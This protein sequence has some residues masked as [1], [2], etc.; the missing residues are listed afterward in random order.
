MQ[1]LLA[2]PAFVLLTWPLEMHHWEGTMHTLASTTRISMRW[3]GE[4]QLHCWT[5]LQCSI[6]Q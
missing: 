4:L 3:P 6:S 1:P 2:K 5:I